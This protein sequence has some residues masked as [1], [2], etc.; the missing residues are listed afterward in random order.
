M[1]NSVHVPTSEVEAA[2]LLAG[3]EKAGD[4]SAIVGGGTIVVPQLHRFDRDPEHVVD[5]WRSGL[6]QVEPARPGWVRLGAMVT[7]QQILDD[8]EV[9]EQLP[10]L[11]SMCSQITG[12]IQIRTQGTVGGSACAARPHSDVPTVLLALGAVMRVRHSSGVREIPIEDWFRGGERSALRRGELLAAIDLPVPSRGH[13][14]LHHKVK[15]A[16]GSWP[17]VTVSGI[18]DSRRARVAVGGVVDR[19]LVLESDA[20]EPMTLWE[21]RVREALASATPEEAR[22]DL[23]ADADYRRDVLLK[24]AS[25]IHRSLDRPPADERTQHGH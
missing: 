10:L 5:L 16:E 13:Q 8:V 9:S 22:S 12:G 7:Y 11:A 2:A 20:D 6:N 3:F 17:I 19:P 21:Q 1:S 18:R 14:S 15:T 24:I 23:H 25:G 4:E